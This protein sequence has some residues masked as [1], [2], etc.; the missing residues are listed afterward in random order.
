MNAFNRCRNKNGVVECLHNFLF[1]PIKLV[2]NEGLAKIPGQSAVDY[3]N[4][5]TCEDSEQNDFFIPSQNF[6]LHIGF[7]FSCARHKHL[8][9]SCLYQDLLFQRMYKNA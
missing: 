2:K 8:S 3:D 6:L 7:H 1:R 5:V 4:R 9:K